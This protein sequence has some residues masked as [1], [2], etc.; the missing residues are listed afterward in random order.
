VPPRKRRSVRLLGLA[1]Q[2]LAEIYEYI[3][4]DNTTAAERLLTRIE[5]EL[6]A[7]AKQ[8]LRRKSFSVSDPTELLFS[9][10]I[11]TT[12]ISADFPQ[13]NARK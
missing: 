3:A 2:D 5:K 12:R 13:G 9:N 7:L 1:E 4:A 11:H 6:N 10:M 8:P